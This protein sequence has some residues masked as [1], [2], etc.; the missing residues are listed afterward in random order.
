MVDSR[1]VK[2][3]YIVEFEKLL[4]RGALN[5][6]TIKERLHFVSEKDAKNW[7]NDVQSFD[8]NSE[9]LNFTINPVVKKSLTT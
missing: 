6:L 5:G 7:V 1:I 4:K 2:Y 9:Y 8:K 3:D